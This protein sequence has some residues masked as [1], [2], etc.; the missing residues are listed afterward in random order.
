MSL[1][2]F[3]QVYNLHKECKYI[4]CW[5]KSDLKL[6]KCNQYSYKKT[7]TKSRAIMTYWIFFLFFS[8]LRFKW[9]YI[10][11][12]LLL[13]LRKI[14][15]IFKL[16]DLVSVQP[17]YT[18]YLQFCQ[19]KQIF[20]HFFIKIKLNFYSEQKSV[21]L[22]LFKLFF[23]IYFSETFCYN[24]FDNITVKLKERCLWLCPLCL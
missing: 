14:Q 4:W 23:Y 11:A 17:Y 21:I 7:Q 20:H 9:F 16:Y 22:N 15:R 10:K 12:I 24:R 19:Q 8:P 18:T 5:K 6:K 3:F 13:L 1:Q 2:Q